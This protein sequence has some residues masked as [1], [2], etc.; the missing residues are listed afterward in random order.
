MQ[1]SAGKNSKMG[2]QSSEQEKTEKI[3]VMDTEATSSFWYPVDDH[4]KTGRP[5]D[6]QVYVPTGMTA[7]KVKKV[8]IPNEK[9]NY[10][11]RQCYLLPNLSENSLCSV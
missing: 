8:I 7:Q 1:V 3:V 10:K 11:A 4:I 5:S 9:L 2:M 6:K